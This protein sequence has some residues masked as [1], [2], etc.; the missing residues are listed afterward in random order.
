MTFTVT[1]RRDTVAMN[2]PTATVASP[3]AARVYM[4]TV[5]HRCDVPHPIHAHTRTHTHTRTEIIS[6]Q[7]EPS[8]RC[9]TVRVGR[10]R[11][12]HVRPRFAGAH[13]LPNPRHHAPTRPQANVGQQ[14]RGARVAPLTRHKGIAWFLPG[15]ENALM[16]AGTVASIE[17]LSSR[18]KNFSH[19]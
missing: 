1:H 8:R 6:A 3:C 19:L 18:E 5:A 4:P 17:R 13:G 16:P 10:Q 14:A 7:W 15:A 11:S 2:S 12:H 9:A